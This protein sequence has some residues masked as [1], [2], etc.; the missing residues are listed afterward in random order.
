MYIYTI[1]CVSVFA[2]GESY[3]VLFIARSVQGVGSSCSSVAG[4]YEDKNM[5]SIVH[6]KNDLLAAKY[7][8]IKIMCCIITTRDNLCVA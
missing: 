1:S 8:Q 4:M 7:L 6:I 3:L 2:F 5:N